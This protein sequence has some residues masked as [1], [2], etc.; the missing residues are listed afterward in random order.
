MLLPPR[1]RKPVTPCMFQNRAAPGKILA[2]ILSRWNVTPSDER[3]G[4]L[5]E[6]VRTVANSD[7]LH[8]EGF[9]KYAGDQSLQV[10]LYQLAVDVKFF[11]F[12]SES[13]ELETYQIYVRI[14]G[15]EYL[16]SD[17]LTGVQ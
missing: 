12:L 11:I 6:F 16:E 5:S 4:Y 17:V 3:Y 15:S 2:A 10:D 14:K 13:L 1:V 7:L 8:L 9:Q